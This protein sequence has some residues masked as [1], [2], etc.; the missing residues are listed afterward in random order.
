MKE[1]LSKIKE[2]LIIKWQQIQ[3]QPRYQLALQYIQ[4]HRTVVSAVSVALF[5]LFFTISILIANNLKGK[6]NTMIQGTDYQ[7]NQSFNH[8]PVGANKIE[9]LTQEPETEY[10]VPTNIKKQG[11]QETIIN[12]FE[13]PFQPT[14]TKNQ[15][16]N[17]YTPAGNSGRKFTG[18]P[19][20]ADTI[21]A[22]SEI[23]NSGSG[24][25]GNSQSSQS[26]GGT[27]GSSGGDNTSAVSENG[28]PYSTPTPVTD[29]QIIFI[30]QNGGFE[31]YVPPAIPPVNVE[32]SRYINYQDHYAI[33][34]PTNWRVVKSPYNSHEGVTLY[35]P[36]IDPNTVDIQS[37]A[38]VGWQMDYLGSS[39]KYSVP[40]IVNG[41]PG[42]LYTSG[43]MG[44]SPIATVFHYAN[45]YFAI[46]SSISDEV[47]IYIYYH[48]LRSL[49]FE[50]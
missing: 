4:L 16:G 48:M 3:A 34:I 8:A 25:S 7:S 18:T 35:L 14:D 6:T 9:Q 26:T 22:Q 31:T 11:I 23:T 1:Q 33:D 42:I 46:G 43:S 41:V 44:R 10:P 24:T 21:P 12:F 32:W 30:N 13:S 39:A 15:N 45:G 37:I 47:F 27:N 50:I 19:K 17:K 28:L 49:N 38:F 5:C 40:I 36:D 29:I 20:A 2:E